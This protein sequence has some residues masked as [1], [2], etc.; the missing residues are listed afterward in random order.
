MQLRAGWAGLAS[1]FMMKAHLC[2]TISQIG[3]GDGTFNAI[4]LD[5]VMASVVGSA[6]PPAPGVECGNGV[7]EPGHL[8]SGSPQPRG[9]NARDE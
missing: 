5:T 7:K 3:L 2:Q 9:P 1:S 8:S 6:P 4:A